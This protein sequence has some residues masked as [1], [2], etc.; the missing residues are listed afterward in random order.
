MATNIS[1]HSSFSK[2]GAFIFARQPRYLQAETHESLFERFA[3]WRERRAAEAE[4]AR[5][6]DRELADIGV[7]RQGIRAAVRV[8]RAIR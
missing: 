7:S 1:N 4:L 2:L 8:H 3:A 5:M 6:S